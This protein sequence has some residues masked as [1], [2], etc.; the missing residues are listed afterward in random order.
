[1]VFQLDFLDVLLLHHIFNS[2]IKKSDCCWLTCQ[3]TV[4]SSFRYTHIR[5]ALNHH[6]DCPLLNCDNCL[7]AIDIL[8][9]ANNF[10]TVVDSIVTTMNSCIEPEMNESIYWEI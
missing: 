4:E 1:M 6:K 3:P 8:T 7:D 5:S 10:N 2:K 9:K